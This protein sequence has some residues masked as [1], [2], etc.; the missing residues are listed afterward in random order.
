MG[1]RLDLKVGFSCNN[2]C[3][4]CAQAH[5]R[6][7][8][9]RTTEEIKKLLEEGLK[10]S[11]DE[12][13]FTGG[14]PTIRNDLIELVEYAKTLGY[15][16]IQIQTNGRR[17]YYQKFVEKI[18]EAGAT[19]FAPA[20][21]GHN[22]I[23][24]DIQTRSKGSFKQTFNGIK[25][26]KDYGQY[27]ITNT[28]ITKINYKYLPEIAD[29]LIKLEV[30]QFQFAFVHPIGNAWKY[31]ELVVPRKKDVVPYLIKALDLAIDVG[32]KPGE[33]MVEAFPPCLMPGYEAFCS[34][35][36][37]PPAEVM[38]FEQ[39][40]EE[41]EKWRKNEGKLK[42]PQC[43]ECKFK[44]ICEGPWR[45]YVWKYGPNEFQPIK[46][47]MLNATEILNTSFKRIDLLE[48]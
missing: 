39:K 26:L 45:E 40:I 35:F 36:Y 23:I 10:D 16:V 7:F 9:D 31:F 21:H 28:V 8:G 42:F 3:I 18:I 38:D 13:V 37:I 6:N 1:K 29:M 5:K 27:I 24:H 32:Y 25:N 44:N 33:V 12:V 41:F 14:E 4:F 20:I 17:F 30:N 15:K 48:E 2:N 43:N 11:C 22:E 19:E 47:E 46:G 34:E